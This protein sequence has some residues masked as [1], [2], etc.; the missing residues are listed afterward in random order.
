MCNSLRRERLVRR[1]QKATLRQSVHD[2]A[3]YVKTEFS[4]RTGQG[5]PIPLISHSTN[6]YWAPI[7]HA[8][9]YF[10]AVDKMD[11]NLSPWGANSSK[12]G[13][14]NKVIHSLSFTTETTSKMLPHNF[15]PACKSA[16]TCLLF[17]L[18]SLEFVPTCCPC[19]HPGVDTDDQPR[20]TAQPQAGEGE[21]YLGMC[22]WAKLAGRRRLN[23]KIYEKVLQKQRCPRARWSYRSVL[24]SLSRWFSSPHRLFLSP[25]RWAWYRVDQ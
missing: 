22:S 18:R 1:S 13:F 21:F 12:R 9:C 14:S 8:S 23:R 6:M 20:N 3:L 24:S 19:I 2:T 10:R 25:Y 7:L 5:R 11:K 16:L 17:L 4:V 15:I